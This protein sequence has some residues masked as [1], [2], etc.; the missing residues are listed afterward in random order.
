V[1]IFVAKRFRYK[2]VRWHSWSLVG[3]T[4]PVVA[5]WCRSLQ[6]A[7]ASCCNGQRW[8]TRAMLSDAEELRPPQ[9]VHTTIDPEALA[10]AP[11]TRGAFSFSAG[12]IRSESF[13]RLRCLQGAAL[14]SLRSGR[15]VSHRY[16]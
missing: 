1:Y 3:S 15:A 12:V 10:L 16:C 9:V 6:A 14:T 11:D 13:L 4:T 2:Q 8:R 5:E 7:P